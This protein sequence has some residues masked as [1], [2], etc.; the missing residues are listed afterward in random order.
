M[1]RRSCH[2]LAARPI[3]SSGPS[4]RLVA[5]PRAETRVAPERIFSAAGPMFRIRFPPALSQQRTDG[6]RRCGVSEDMFI[7]AAQAIAEQV[8]EENL[9]MELIYPPQNHILEGGV[10]RAERIA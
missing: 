1:Q 8:I 7:I 9:S 5:V 2:V 4:R 6:A 3:A 10:G